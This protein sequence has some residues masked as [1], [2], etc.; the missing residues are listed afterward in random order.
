LSKF[1]RGRLLATCCLASAAL[2]QHVPAF[3]AKDAHTP[4]SVSASVSSSAPSL[5]NKKVTLQGGIDRVDFALKSSG[6]TLDDVKLPAL[7]GNVRLGSPAYYGGLAEG[8][9]VLSATIVENKL[10]LLFERKG[11]RFALSVHTSPTDFGK[12]VKGVPVKDSAARD[13]PAKN[14]AANGKDADQP[15]VP[16]KP[17]TDQQKLTELAKHDLVIL[18]DTSASM[19]EPIPSL[20]Q[21][22]WQWCARFLANFA[23][24]TKDALAGRGLTIIPFNSSYTIMRSC[25]TDQVNKLFATTAPNGG[26]DFASPLQEVLSS[27]IASGR[28]RPLM[29][30]VFTDGIPSYGPKVEQVLINATKQLRSAREVKLTFLAIGEDYNGASLLTY[31]DDFLVHEGAHFDVVQTVAFDQLQKI[32][33]V[34]ALMLVLEH[35]SE[36]QGGINSEIAKLREQIENQR[37]EAEKLEGQGPALRK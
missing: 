14:L 13:V 10:N 21:S 7:V 30:A 35:K 20:R 23:E 28:Q 29:I 27:Y 32:N 31:L 34:D 36:S 3:A 33:L 37:L 1:D 17:L 8:D 18:I 5:S 15:F 16:G 26:T 9:K 11:K 19:A 12:F 4:S 24:R 6:V 25:S 22:K 2:L